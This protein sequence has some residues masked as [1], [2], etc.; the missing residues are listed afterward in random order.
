MTDAKSADVG[1]ISL[2]R[3]WLD[4][5]VSER[6]GYPASRYLEGDE[7][8]HGRRALAELLRDGNAPPDILELLARSLMPDDEDVYDQ[9][10]PRLQTH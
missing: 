9:K 10:E 5:Y 1:K 2:A 8:L 7:D 3:A 6:K 4:G